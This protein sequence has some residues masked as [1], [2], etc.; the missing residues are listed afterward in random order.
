MAAEPEK[1]I[2]ELLHAYSRKR[3][4]DA[5]APL[6]PHP[7]TR[8]MLQGEV[9]RQFKAGAASSASPRPW[10]KTLL[11]FGPK[12]A[13]AIGMFAILALG[14]W[15]IT[16]Q[17]HDSRSARE[18]VSQQTAAADADA[19]RSLEESAKRSSE[20]LREV[21]DLA[22]IR[23]ARPE[24]LNKKAEGTKGRA[25][26][27]EDQEKVQLR[28]A[29]NRPAPSAA[30]ARPELKVAEQLGREKQVMLQRQEEAGQK[31][32]EAVAGGSVLSKD[33]SAV[34]AGEAVGVQ[35]N[36]F[37]KLND[38]KGD[39]IV[40]PPAV[41]QP[42]TAG[43]DF[44]A[45]KPTSDVQLG[46]SARLVTNAGGTEGAA[47]FYRGVNLAVTATTN[48]PSQASLSFAD[49]FAV[50]MSEWS[51]VIEP[52]KN[53]IAGAR[54]LSNVTQEFEERERMTP[55]LLRKFSV[56]QNN[57]RIRIRDA[58]DGSVYDGEV[59][60]AS[61]SNVAAKEATDEL[62]RLRRSAA[63]ARSTPVTFRASGVNQRSKQVVIINGELSDEQERIAGVAGRLI[64]E[65]PA[66]PAAPAQTVT[67][68]ATVTPP[69]D[70]AAAGQRAQ[71]GAV[72]QPQGQT[73]AAPVTTTAG[74]AVTG[75]T[76]AGRSNQL[77]GATT[78]RARVQIGAT[79]ELNMRAIRTK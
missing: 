19:S 47:G 71:A 18:V 56:E 46:Y 29:E 75:T 34:L 68:P 6:E 23:P 70:L 2:E 22:G 52:T 12:Y 31:I 35:E 20:Q 67:A 4:E 53:E 7:A 45:A 60:A 58:E 14:V 43:L 16:Q 78:L 54:V 40:P 66:A 64:T 59:L 15:V 8:R 36:R 17:D 30:P 57:G 77:F 32:A 41:N 44:A 24:S 39:T 33:K 1:K 49:G 76:A 21:D 13:G 37:Y 25:D 62:R 38:G 9:A 28:D 11:L 5:G 74:V 55:A 73:R 10:W 48:A 3:R 26:V 51:A 61:E 63:D 72:R 79:N 50:P 42:I 27:L 69:A 65:T